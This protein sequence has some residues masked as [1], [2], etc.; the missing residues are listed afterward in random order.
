MIGLVKDMPETDMYLQ[1]PEKKS[2]C[3]PNKEIKASQSP[4]LSLTVNK[5][6]RRKEGAEN[7]QI[8]QTNTPAFSRC[9]RCMHCRSGTERE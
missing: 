8:K 6:E 1:K 3:S 2:S 5:K 9:L 7:V 4:G